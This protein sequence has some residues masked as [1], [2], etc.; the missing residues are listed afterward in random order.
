[1]QQ[2]LF[3]VEKVACLGCCMLAPAVQIDDVI[4]GY[5][6]HETIPQVLQDFLEQQK[7]AAT[8]SGIRKTRKTSYR[9]RPASV[10]I[11]VAGLLAAIRF[12]MLL[13]K[14]AA[15]NASSGEE[16]KTPAATA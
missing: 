8:V 3:T 12:M 11:P 15:A 7:Q 4:Y 5:L 9:D 1:M 13:Q 14:A 6:T 2:R 16:S 10:W